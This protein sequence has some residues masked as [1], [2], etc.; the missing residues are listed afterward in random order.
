M[1]IGDKYGCLTVLDNGEEYI[2]TTDYQDFKRKYDELSEKLKGY[3]EKREDIL[4]S[5][6][7]LID[8]DTHTIKLVPNKRELYCELCDLN[9]RINTSGLKELKCKLETHYKCQC[10]C[11]K[12]HFYNV[13]TIENNPKYCLYPVS[14]SNRMTY[15]VSAQNATYRKQQRYKEI[16]NVVFVNKRTDSFPSKEYCSLW[17][18][19][20]EKE[21]SKKSVGEEKAYYI[22]EYDK[23]KNKIKL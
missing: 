23:S 2:S 17:N 4:N 22:E 21:L 14:I 15:S 12:I 5:N 3:I 6:P 8:N 10:K 9:L 7:D 20:K 19:Y 13:K 11:G 16:E 18:E 1:K